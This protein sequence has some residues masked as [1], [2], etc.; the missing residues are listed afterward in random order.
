M[1]PKHLIFLAVIL[2]ILAGLL[3]I[4]KMRIKPEIQLSEYK[5][6][7]I[8]F[9]SSKVYAIEINKAGDTGPLSIIKDGQD[10][11]IASKWNIKAKKQ[12]I[13]QLLKEIS[14][15]Q[16]ERRSNSKGVFS[17]YEIS[18][19]EAF[20]IIL[21]D[22]NGKALEHLFIGTVKPSYESSF[23]RK[24]DSAEVYLTDK[25]IF[26]LIG[27]YEDPKEATISPDKWVDL[28]VVEFDIEK[29]ESIKI[30]RLGEEGITTLDIKRELDEE[31]NLQQWVALKQEPVFDLDAKKIKNL[32]K[33][34]NK[35][36]A[37]KAVDPDGEG[38][39]FDQPFLK[40]LL[41]GEEGPL[42]LILG[43]IAEENK[44][45]RYVKSPTGYVYILPEYRIKYI[46]I[47]TSSFFIDNPL[48]VNKDKI[49]SI[50]IKSDKEVITLDKDLI[51]K[52]QNYINNLMKFAVE[53]ML[54]DSKGVMPP[55]K[56]SLVLT[57]DNQ[58][59]STLNLKKQT[60]DKFIAQLD[61]K[62]DVFSISKA[63]FDK[64]FTGLD[65]LNL[66]AE[67]K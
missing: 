51:G 63:V 55:I 6:L 17:D 10:W 1:K 16:G 60:E 12:M 44:K 64:V 27:I 62:P 38:Y 26:A 36:Y 58:S 35:I 24:L 53:K 37:S 2:V 52:N 61:G 15:L 59:I 66:T 22:K 65:K 5:S 8:S 49:E 18:D 4:K 42:E 34:I 57:R 47:D 39:G 46:D 28:T 67:D 32:L 13:E 48:R 45:D 29:I 23:L 54:F 7:E 40:V 41:T 11:L 3:Y 30:S 31:K 56:Y 33:Q 50:T 21:S 20:S 25:D 14:G 9:D 19:Q 43:N